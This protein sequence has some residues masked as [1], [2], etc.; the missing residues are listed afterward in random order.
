M[1]RFKYGLTV[2]LAWGALTV[3]AQENT[4]AAQF[5]ALTPDVRG[6]GMGNTGVASKADAFSLYRNVAKSV[7]AKKKAAVGYSFTPWLRELTDDNNLHGVAG[8]YNLDDRQG[9]VAGFRWFSHAEVELIGKDGTSSGNFTPKDWSV[10]LGYSRKLAEGLSVGAVA[11]FVR[12]ELSDNATAN[13][14]AFDLG[15]YYRRGFAG[16]EAAGWAVGLQASNFGTRIDYGYGKYDQPAKVT[17]G[18]TVDYDFT[19]NHRLS[20]SL[21]AGCRV[22]PSSC[23][24]GGVGAEYTGW[25]IVSVRGGYHWGEEDNKMQRYGTLGLGLGYKYVRADFSWLVP[26]VDSL[27]KNT[28]QV[29]VSFEF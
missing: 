29:A 24:E 15:V 20:G 8:Y 3:S 14:V 1:K 16:N 18:G 12:S 27:L 5:P 22:L 26:E 19:E 17:L 11:R 13:A 6:V 21:E 4:G 7:F 25:N 10:D 28:W 2:L 9:I 23:F